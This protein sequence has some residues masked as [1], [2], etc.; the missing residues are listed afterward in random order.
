M[1]SKNN[2]GRNNNFNSLFKGAAT[3]RTTTGTSENYAGVSAVQLVDAIVKPSQRRSGRVPLNRLR[4]N[5]RQQR[6]KKSFDQAEL[7]ELGES[8][9]QNGLLQPIIVRE[10]QEPGWLDVIAGERRWRAMQLVDLFDAEAIILDR[11]CTEDQMEQIALA[12]NLH[13]RDLTPEELAHA[14]YSLHK[15]ANG[16]PIRTLDEISALV[17]KSVTHIDD[18]LA[19]I[20]APEN[21]RALIVENPKVPLRTIRDLSN[22]DDPNERDYLLEQVRQGILKANDISA[23]RQNRKKEQARAA[24]NLTTSDEKV[25]ASD[26]EH[27]PQSS[28]T[29]ESKE[30]EVMLAFPAQEGK[31]RSKQEEDNV[32][33][34][35]KESSQRQVVRP[36]SIEI[37]V[38]VLE[39]RLLKDQKPIQR[40]AQALQEEIVVMSPQE[41]AC[42]KRIVDQW[43]TWFHQI[44]ESA[45]E[46]ATIE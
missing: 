2:N 40:I 13:R 39:R 7:L 25:P 16:K 46:S 19:I 4:P 32:S 3:G 26:T 24:R 33:S 28:N 9:R 30:K 29:A 41:K 1:M 27:P 12:E 43:E 22:V 36:P 8:I 17:G 34:E 45:S 21:V 23:I 37:A 42:V 20:R 10:A 35:K 18:H 14:Y 31:D 11:S 44:L 38:A 15:D 5:P 6:Q